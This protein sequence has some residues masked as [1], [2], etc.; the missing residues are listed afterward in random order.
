MTE[1]GG[2]GGHAGGPEQTVVV[3]LLAIVGVLLVVLLLSSRE[4]PGPGDR[5]GGSSR[6]GPGRSAKYVGSQACRRCHQEIAA[7]YAGHPMAR[8]LSPVNDALS[9]EDFASGLEGFTAGRRSYRVERQGKQVM[10]FESMTGDDTRPLY[11]QG[12]AIAYAIG[13]GVKGRSYL[14]QRKGLFFE[15]PITWYTHK[16]AWDLSPGYS[17]ALHY[18][19]SRRVGDDR[20]ACHAGRVAVEPEATVDRYVADRPFL[21][22]SIGCERCHGPG[23]EHVA[24]Y[25]ESSDG[26]DVTDSRIVILYCCFLLA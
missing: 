12:E 26:T 16:K 17:P 21:E 6:R 22:A 9:I 11:E 20:L 2:E 15:S 8:T 25:E 4:D 23:S 19:F 5:A 3:G 24:I 1:T 7:S 10:H 14:L 18:R 13:A